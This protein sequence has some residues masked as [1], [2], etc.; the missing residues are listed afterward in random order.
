MIAAPALVVGCLWLGWTGQYEAV[1]WI[2][3][4]LATVLVGFAISLVFMSFL[5][6]RPR[7]VS[8]SRC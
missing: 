3:P 5:V 4:A 2:V 8:R 1:P 6:R 7:S